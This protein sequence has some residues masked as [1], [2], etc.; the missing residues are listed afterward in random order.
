MNLPMNWYARL[1]IAALCYPVANMTGVAVAIIAVGQ[2]AGLRSLRDG[3]A[4]QVIFATI[5]IALIETLLITA[6]LNLMI[7]LSLPAAILLQQWA[8][9]T[10]LKRETGLDERPMIEQAW[11][12]VAREVVSATAAAAVMRINTADPAA[13][14]LVARIQAGCDAIGQSGR[15]GL[16]ILLTDCPGVSAD[17]IAARLRSALQLN[18][19][20]ATVAV[21]AKPRDG[22]GLADLLA[23]CEAELIAM[24]AASRAEAAP[25]PNQ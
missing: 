25:K 10:Q 11:Q 18:K 5:G 21:A 2:Y 9:T 1:G 7:W 23:V 12:L 19:L 8:V 17:A 15:S 4:H 24:D 22:H 3:L 6:H 14:T 16:A 20:E 13:A